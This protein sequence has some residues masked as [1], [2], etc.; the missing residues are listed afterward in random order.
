MSYWYSSEALAKGFSNFKG[1]LHHFV[2]AKLATSSIGVK[3]V[4]DYSTAS[5]LEMEIF[6]EIVPGQCCLNVKG[7]RPPFFLF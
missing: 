5:V 3:G 2:F 1:F 6:L 4:P 7:I